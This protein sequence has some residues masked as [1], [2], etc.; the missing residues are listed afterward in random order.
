[1]LVLSRKL[2][3]SILIGDNIVVKVVGIENGMVKL[4]IDA[5]RDISI[6][7]NELIEE[8][9]EQNRAAVHIAEQSELD[10]LSKLLKK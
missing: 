2:D 3:E 9:K 7:R 5:P 10:E 8:V 6:I 4:G 1:M